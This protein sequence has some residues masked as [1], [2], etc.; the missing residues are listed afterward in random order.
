M[1]FQAL[2][3]LGGVA[4]GNTALCL[5]KPGDPVERAIL[6]QIA[7][8]DPA[9]FEAY[10]ATHPTIP[11][12]TLKSRGFM[13]SFVL[14]VEGELTFC[15]LNRQAGWSDKTAAGLD[16]LPILDLSRA[17]PKVTPIP[18]WDCLTVTTADLHTHDHCL[19]R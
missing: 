17:P 8:S 11:Q 15:G 10:Q 4:P 18:A 12:A 2:L 16:A 7:E 1:D 14:R 3:A 13:A 5:H 6:C 19:N 9:L